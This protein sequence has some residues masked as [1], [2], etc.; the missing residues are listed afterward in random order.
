MIEAHEVDEIEYSLVLDELRHF[1]AR[2]APIGNDEVVLV[3]RDISERKGHEIELQQLHDQLEARLDDLQR[4]RELVQA[5]VESAPSYFC[6]VDIEG[7]IRRF[8]RALE[9]ASGCGEDS[10]TRNRF[11]WDVFVAE[12]DTPRVRDV[13]L[14]AARTDTPSDEQEDSVACRGRLPNGRRLDDHAAL[15]GRA[16]RRDADQRHGRDRAQAPRGRAAPLPRPP[17]RGRERRAPAPG[18]EPPRRRPAAPRRRSRCRCGSRRASSRPRRTRPSGCSRPPSEE[19]GHALEELRELARGIH[20]A[21]LTDR[22]LEPALESLVMRA[23]VPVTLAEAPDERL[24][25]GV[26]A[27]A[28]YVVSEALTNVAKYADGLGRDGAGLAPNGRAVVEVADDGVGG[29]DPALGSGLRG[30]ADRVEALDGRLHVDSVPGAGH[31]D[32]RRDPRSEYSAVAPLGS[33]AMRVVL[34]DDSVLLREGVARILEDADFEVV[35]QAGNPEELLL[36][37]RSY[38]PDVAVVDI[39]MPPTHTDEG[40]QAAKEIRERYPERGVLVLSQYLE[41]GLRAGAPV[42]ERRGRRLP[43]EGPRRGRGRV[44]RGRAARRRGRLGARPVRRLAARRPPP[45]GRSARRADPASAR[46][47]ASWRR[48]ARTPASRSASS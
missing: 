36:K 21:I 38:S 28:Y 41:A 32:P 30:L 11:F 12:E 2:V 18:A 8:N 44:R 9:L 5:V 40:L 26:E 25:E 16:K 43:A 29:A 45:R 3:V 19:L 17:R 24:P 1:E 14:E 13:I 42:G 10:G 22:G 6:L 4:E 31:D 7:R 33:S 39:R 46:C 47:W 20:P 15:R 37:V 35:G 23:P 34:A 48:A 27:A